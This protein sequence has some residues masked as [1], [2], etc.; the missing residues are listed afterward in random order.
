[1]KMPVNGRSPSSEGSIWEKR[2]G[3]PRSGTPLSFAHLVDLHV[4]DMCD[5][6]KAPRRSKQ[7]TLDALKAKLGKVKLKDL[8]GNA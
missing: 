2:R 5:V 4:Q 6:G 1:M 3:S 8:S 7:F